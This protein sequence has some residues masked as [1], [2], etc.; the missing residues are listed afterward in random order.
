[1]FKV[2]LVTFSSDVLLVP[3]ATGS[4]LTG[5][6]RS[7]MG[8]SLVILIGVPSVFTEE[9]GCVHSSAPPAVLLGD[10]SL[11]LIS[12]STARGSVSNGVTSC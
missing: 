5:S 10:P 4:G 9:L 7:G 12:F 1:M 11:S 2:V 8:P 6:I 3:F